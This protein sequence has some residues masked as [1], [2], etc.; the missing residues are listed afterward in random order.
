MGALKVELVL[1][2]LLYSFNWELPIRMKTEELDIDTKPGMVVH[3]KN[4]LCLIAK[5]SSE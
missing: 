5:E 3:K 4:H 1:S 2:N